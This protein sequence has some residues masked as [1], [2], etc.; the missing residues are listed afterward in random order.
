M[1]KVYMVKHDV[2]DV[3]SVVVY[4]TMDKSK[5]EEIVETFISVDTEWVDDV[6]ENVVTE[7]CRIE[8]YPMDV[9]IPE[10]DEVN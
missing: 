5:A 2:S 6:I 3:E 8:E 10:Y 1:N 4:V 9:I 7:L